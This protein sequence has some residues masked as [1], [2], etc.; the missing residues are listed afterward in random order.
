MEIGHAIFLFSDVHPTC[1]ETK[2]LLYNIT[3]EYFP[4][5]ENQSVSV[6][7]TILNGKTIKNGFKLGSKEV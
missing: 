3:C 1:I 7:A 5:A 2:F 4:G 6:L